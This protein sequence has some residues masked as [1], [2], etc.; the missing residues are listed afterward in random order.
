MQGGLRG[1]VTASSLCCW[2]V[3]SGWGWVGLCG[4]VGW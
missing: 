3:G 1:G 2:I 4:W